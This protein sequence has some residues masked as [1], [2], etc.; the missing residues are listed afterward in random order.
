MTNA[1]CADEL[2]KCGYCFRSLNDGTHLVIDTAKGKINY[3][4]GNGFFE[5]AATGKGLKKL[6]SEL[7]KIRGVGKWN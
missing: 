2:R 4:P 1:D 6:K 7:Q 3:Y 5:G